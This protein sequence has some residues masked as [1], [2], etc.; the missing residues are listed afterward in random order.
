[1]I[2]DI[3]AEKNGVVSVRNWKPQGKLKG[4]LPGE[5]ESTQQ[6]QIR[7]ISIHITDETGGREAREGDRNILEGKEKRM[8]LQCH[9]PD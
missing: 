8:E 1:L 2:T 6:Q 7:G 9:F 5:E 4:D 3:F